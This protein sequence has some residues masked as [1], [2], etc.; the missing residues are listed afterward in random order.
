M[1]RF[2]FLSFFLLI[3]KGDFMKRF[4]RVCL[5]FQ[6]AFNLL[7]FQLAPVAHAEELTEVTVTEAPVSQYATA[8]VDTDVLAG[9]VYHKINNPSMAFSTVTQYAWFTHLGFYFKNEKLTYIKESTN[10][11]G[12]D[13]YTYVQSYVLS[14][15][16]ANLV[17]YVQREENEGFFGCFDVYYCED[18]IVKKQPGYMKVS[19]PYGIECPMYTNVPVFTSLDA[20]EYF[21]KNK[22]LRSE[23]DLVTK[24]LPEGY[25]YNETLGLKLGSSSAEVGAYDENI[26]YP[27]NFDYKGNLLSM[28]TA[29]SSTW[30]FYKDANGNAITRSAEEE[31]Y[32]IEIFLNFDM[33]NDFVNFFVNGFTAEG[34]ELQMPARALFY[35]DG[36]ANSCSCVY[37]NW[38]ETLLRG[39]NYFKDKG[40]LTLRDADDADEFATLI[41]YS[42]N[43][44]VWARYYYFDD[45]GEK[46][47]GDWVK[48]S[49]EGLSVVHEDTSS[50][51][52][53]TV[54]DAVPFGPEYK[55]SFLEKEQGYD[56]DEQ[57][58]TI[59]GITINVSPYFESQEDDPEYYPTSTD[60]PSGDDDTGSSGGSGSSSSEGSGSGSGIF[61]QIGEILGN[62]IGGIV[63]LFV[64]LLKAISNSIYKITKSIGD[65]L[66]SISNVGDIFGTVF[67]WLPGEIVAL[68][69]LAILACIVCRVLGR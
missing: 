5:A 56:A 48:W 8:P 51:T 12:Y 50:G 55:S 54:E 52:E 68:L 24:Y 35:Y 9:G 28:N 31:K 37:E 11:Y 17:F 69:S 34:E 29:R 41:F 63:E 38:A 20:G 44:N 58:I 40:K 1:G 36:A 3:G 18:G 43:L 27:I 19:K 22:K 16:V 33:K 21:Y 23:D 61:S 42:R 14:K 6:V 57:K 13:D 39:I 26:G 32:N 2:F 67:G 45:A 25:S 47:F 59:D 4:A 53:S 62:L 10:F 60:S 64:G 15:D 46:H 30:D 49:K 66:S 65:F 7:I